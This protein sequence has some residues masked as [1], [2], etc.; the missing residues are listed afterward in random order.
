MAEVIPATEK[1]DTKKRE[2]I[3]TLINSVKNN[4]TTLAELEKW[5]KTVILKNFQESRQ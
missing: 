1:K 4:R 5:L 2:E 3:W